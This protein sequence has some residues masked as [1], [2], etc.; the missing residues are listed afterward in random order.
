MSDNIVTP[1]KQI[2]SPG[3]RATSSRPVMTDQQAIDRH[4][5]GYFEFLRMIGVPTPSKAE[6]RNL[7]YSELYVKYMQE[8]QRQQRA[9]MEKLQQNLGVTK[10]AVQLLDEMQKYKVDI[11]KVL[12]DAKQA[13][14]D[15]QKGIA[16]AETVEAPKQEGPNVEESKE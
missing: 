7:L 11:G 6:A 8:L 9:E 1:N 14:E 13:Q 2:V 15:E 5:G 12:A 3:G 16:Q 10:Q 4:L